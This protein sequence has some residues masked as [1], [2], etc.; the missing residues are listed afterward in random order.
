MNKRRPAMKKLTTLWLADGIVKK[1]L[2]GALAAG[3]I[4]VLASAFAFG[5]QD[6]YSGPT[7]RKWTMG[8]TLGGAFPLGEFKANNVHVGGG[9]D[10][11]L[12]RRLGDSPLF[13]GFDLCWIIYGLR[14]SHEYL[15]TSIP[16]QVEVQTANNILQ[17]LFYLKYR[18]G[19]GRFRPYVEALAGISYLFTDTSIYSE[20]GLNFDEI[21]SD[22]N[23][24]DITFTVGAGAGMEFR[25]GRGDGNA[26]GRRR[27]EWLI[28]V[29]ARYMAGGTAKYL[30]EDSII[31]ENGQYTYLYSRS[32]TDFISV[33]VGISANF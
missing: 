6:S 15:S 11:S 4:L 13:G 16:M 29:K 10:I 5:D 33:Q 25:L 1:T 7:G 31:Y 26:Y 14:T 12:G 32:R 19:K 3:A 27:T 20:S 23:F 21:A 24:D 30:R 17:G 22:V 28:D 9:L 18:P 8:F 2:V